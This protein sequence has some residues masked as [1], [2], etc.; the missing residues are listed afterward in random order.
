[1]A[2]LDIHQDIKDKLNTFIVEKKYPILYFMGLR[3]VVKDIYY[4]SLSLIFTKQSIISN[5][6]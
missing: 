1:M 2:E 6:M 3:D 4:V 5:G